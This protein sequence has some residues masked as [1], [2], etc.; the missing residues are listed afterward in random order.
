[1]IASKHSGDHKWHDAV[2]RTET[3]GGAPLL[4]DLLVFIQDEVS[5]ALPFTANLVL[6]LHEYRYIQYFVHGEYTVK[7]LILVFF[8]KAPSNQYFLLQILSTHSPKLT[9]PPTQNSVFLSSSPKSIGP[10]LL[11][12]CGDV[13]LTEGPL[14]SI[15][16]QRPFTAF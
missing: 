7:C 15:S 5:T 10:D 16:N 8:K 2:L 4:C 12:H 9:F 1:M 11:I 3:D 13:S 14:R 6:I